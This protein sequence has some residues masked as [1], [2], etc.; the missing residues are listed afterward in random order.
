[1]R[2]GHG[3]L[4]RRHVVAHHGHLQ[5]A[6]G[7]QGPQL[8]PQL[9][10]GLQRVGE[11]RIGARAGHGLLDALALHRRLQ[12]DRQHVVGQG[13]AAGQLHAA[14]VGV[15]RD[16]VRRHEGG[17]AALDQAVDGQAQLVQRAVAG[18]VGGEHGAFDVVG[19]RGH[20]RDG[21]VAAALACQRAQYLH[22]GPTGAQQHQVFAGGVHAHAS[23]CIDR[24][25]RHA[26]AFKRLQR[27]AQ[28]TSAWANSRALKVCRSSSFSPTPM[29]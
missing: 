5:G 1:M 8:R 28:P 13:V 17:A 16:D 29:K 7:G 2:R 6:L 24:A 10:E 11:Q 22:V 21:Q 4:D 27:V 14:A 23:E 20:Q 26:G 15:E 18:H 3:Q 9:H 19:V 12:V 25:Q